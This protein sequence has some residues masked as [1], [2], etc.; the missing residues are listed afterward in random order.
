MIFTIFWDFLKMTIPKIAISM[1]NFKNHIKSEFLNIRE[2]TIV[3]IFVL[4]PQKCQILAWNWKFWN[5]SEFSLVQ[6]GQRLV[7]RRLP[8]LFLGSSSDF[9]KGRPKTKNHKQWKCNGFWIQNFG[10]VPLLCH[11][12]VFNRFYYQ[13]CLL[14]VNSK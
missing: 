13:R 14:S 6:G 5:F 11:W 7:K 1:K 10:K 8:G 2:F 12:H 9:D 3:I 4:F